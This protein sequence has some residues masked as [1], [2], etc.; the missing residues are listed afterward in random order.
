MSE[1]QST[2]LALRH[3]GTELAPYYVPSRE[4]LSQTLSLAKVL[5]ETRGAAIP[6]GIETVQEAAAIIMAGREMGF[7]P[8]T[9]FRRF[10]VV[11]GRTQIDAQ[12]LAA[13]IQEGGGDLIY[14]CDCEKCAD[15]ELIRPGRLP[16]RIKYTMEQAVKA[17]SDKNK[18]GPKHPWVNHPGDM[19]IWKAVTRLAKRGAADLINAVN[20]S[21]VRIEDF[22]DATRQLAPDDVHDAVWNEA[23]PQRALTVG[24]QEVDTDTGEVI[25]EEPP[26]NQSEAESPSADADTPSEN[27]T[28]EPLQTPLT[29]PSP[30]P[31]EPGPVPSTDAPA[32]PLGAS[33]TSTKSATVEAE[34]ASTTTSTPTSPRNL[35]YAVAHAD[36]QAHFKVLSDFQKAIRGRGSMP[37]ASEEM[38]LNEIVEAVGGSWP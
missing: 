31:P 27:T 13:K 6:K 12:G 38:T 2:A 37:E 24:G 15:V 33:D 19:L 25:E 10:Y 23:Q 35:N 1:E 21:M 26:S 34:K 5:M 7:D 9:A 28:S 29:T 20:R 17:G 4:E 16:I 32:E 11:D 8:M 3:A 36:K 22:E 30:T 18:Y 14:H